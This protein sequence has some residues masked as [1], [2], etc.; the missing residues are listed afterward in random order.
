MVSFVS[1][2]TAVAQFYTKIQCVQ[3]KV[4]CGRK[5]QWEGVALAQEKWKG[6]TCLLQ[7]WIH[8]EHEFNYYSQCWQIHL[9]GDLASWCNGLFKW[10]TLARS[11]L[12][13]LRET[14]VYLSSFLKCTDRNRHLLRTRACW[15]I[16]SSTC[17]HICCQTNPRC[18]QVDLLATSCWNKHAAVG[19]VYISQK[20]NSTRR[21]Q[22]VCS[23]RFRGHLCFIVPPFSTLCL[24]PLSLASTSE[25]LGQP[26]TWFSSSSAFLLSETFPLSTL[27]RCHPCSFHMHADEPLY[28]GAD[29]ANYICWK[30]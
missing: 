13:V 18:W 12:S 1:S 20:R 22:C 23:P 4:R 24:L 14:D 16:S 25:P 11:P 8:D 28:D 19:V 7:S 27:F 2:V 21:L 5:E 17:R 10:L 26:P 3:L 29:T 30:V 15:H 6:N 9:L